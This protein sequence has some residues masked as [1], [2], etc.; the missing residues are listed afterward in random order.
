MADAITGGN[1]IGLW[2]V[3]VPEKMREYLLKYETGSLWH[4]DEKS[5]SKQDVPQ[6]REDKNFHGNDHNSYSSPESQWLMI[7]DT[8][9]L[10]FSPQTC[11]KCFTCRLMWADATKCAHFLFR[12]GICHWKHPLERLRSHEHSVE[13]MDAT[14]AFSRRCN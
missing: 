3:S 11:V 8:S 1:N 5:F 13:H 9:W 4:C 6:H 2:P 12:K 10:C 7:V 14:I